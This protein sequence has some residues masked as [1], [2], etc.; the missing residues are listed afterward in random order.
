M[1]F[2]FLVYSVHILEHVGMHARYV[3]HP[4]YIHIKM[5]VNINL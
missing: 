5:S 2:F 3:A 4:N 1:E